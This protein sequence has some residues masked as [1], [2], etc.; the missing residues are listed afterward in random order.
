MN[1]LNLKS[2]VGIFFILLFLFASSLGVPIA[3]CN[4]VLDDNILKI[5]IS[6]TSQIRYEGDSWS[7]SLKMTIKND[8]QQSVFLPNPT[9]PYISFIEEYYLLNPN[10]NEII[11]NGK[12]E[13]VSILSE[14]SWIEIGA[15]KY[16]EAN[17]N[18][19]IYQRNNDGFVRR[20]THR[21]S[22][23]VRFIIDIGKK[24]EDYKIFAKIVYNKHQKA[25]HDFER[26]WINMVDFKPDR[27]EFWHGEIESN[28]LI[29]RDLMQPVVGPNG[30]FGVAH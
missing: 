10:N 19:R 3:V 9:L 22:E 23:E 16:I 24:I 27:T 17:R 29:L 12:P 6:P 13:R 26:E 25:K 14:N 30:H 18:I 7:F 20:D 15:T 2:I 4:E 1:I 28:R 21:Q 11:G 5:E 8:S